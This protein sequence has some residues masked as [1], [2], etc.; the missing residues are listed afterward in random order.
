[1]GVAFQIQDDLLNLEG[2]EF[3][4]TKGYN[5]EDIHEGKITLMVLHYLGH[6]EQS[7]KER[8]VEILR[9]KTTDKEE[10]AEAIL[11]LRDGGSLEYAR[12]KMNELI[13]SSMAEIDQVLPN[14][15]VKHY[16]KELSYFGIKRTK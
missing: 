4:K 2:E 1:M 9:K 14:N 3:I 6:G 7:K 16:L 11:I 5:G 12:G 8:L 13:E 15:R 10:I